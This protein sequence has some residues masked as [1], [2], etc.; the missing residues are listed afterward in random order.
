MPTL[1]YFHVSLSLVKVTCMC[2]RVHG[3]DAIYWL[4]DNVL[5]GTS[6]M[7]NSFLSP[8]AIHGQQ[9]L[10]LGVNLMDSFLPSPC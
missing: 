3:C 6:R 4:M 10:S 1:P 2:L 9:L 5:A 8:A 7:T